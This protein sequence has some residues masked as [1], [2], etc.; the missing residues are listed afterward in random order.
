MPLRKLVTS[1]KEVVTSSGGA[2]QRNSIQPWGRLSYDPEY[3]LESAIGLTELASVYVVPPNSTTVPLIPGVHVE[4]Q[5]SGISDPSHYLP[6]GTFRRYKGQGVSLTQEARNLVDSL[7]DKQVAK[8]AIKVLNKLEERLG[9][10]SYIYDLP[11]IRASEGDDGSLLISWV[12]PH[13]RIG[14]SIE[15]DIQESGWYLV[16]DASAGHIHASGLLNAINLDALVSFLVYIGI[17][18]DLIIK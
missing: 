6:V 3:D 15:P 4:L 13:F 12:Y 11:P 18:N 9:I 17:N 10:V 16:S 5:T 1:T 7:S 14:I 8:E 2:L